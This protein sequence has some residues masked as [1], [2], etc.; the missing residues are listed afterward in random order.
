MVSK[1]Q[2][3]FR[4]DSLHKTESLIAADIDVN[5]RIMRVFTTHLQSV[6]FKTKDFRNVEIIQNAED[7]IVEAYRSW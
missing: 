5:G 1:F 7:S 4:R 2:A 6:L 3:H